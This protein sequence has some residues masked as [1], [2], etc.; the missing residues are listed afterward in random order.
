MRCTGMQVSIEDGVEEVQSP[1][2]P[3][4]AFAAGAIRSESL[5]VGCSGMEIDTAAFRIASSAYIGSSGTAQAMRGA[6]LGP[7]CKTLMVSSACETITLLQDT[8]ALAA[9]SCC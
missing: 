8:D 4:G 9:P 2:V 5:A 1:F 6:P 7:G 3:R